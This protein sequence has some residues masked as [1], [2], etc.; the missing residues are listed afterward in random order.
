VSDKKGHRINVT[1][2]KVLEEQTIYSALQNPI[3]RIKETVQ[4]IVRVYG[5]VSSKQKNNRIYVDIE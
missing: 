5:N 3:D 1:T 2:N 4:L